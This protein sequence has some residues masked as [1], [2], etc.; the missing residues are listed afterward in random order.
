MRARGSVLLLL[1][2]AASGCAPG[3]IVLLPSPPSEVRKEP[4]ISPPAPPS[5]PPVSPAPDAA[6]PAVPPAP[7]PPDYPRLYEEAIGRTKDAISRG[8]P[9]SAIPSWKALE[10]SPWQQ[11]A[12]F[13]QGVLLQLA[14]D[15]D[16][17]KVH[18]IHLAGETPP[19]EPAAANLLG[20]W[21]LRGE[22]EEARALAA[23]LLPEPGAP[24]SGM[25]PELQANL[26]A[27]LAEEG[28]FVQ[29]AQWIRALRA[30]GFDAPALTWNLAVLAYRNGDVAAARKLAGEIPPE[31]ASLWP[32]AASRF[33]WDP[34]QEKAPVFDDVPAAEPRMAA[35]A[36]NLRA[37][38]VYRKGNAKEAGT[39]LAEPAP[40]KPPAELLS[41]LGILAAEQGRWNEARE[42]LERAVREAPLLAA[43]WRNL[44]IFLDIYAGDP[45]GARE[46]YQKYGTLN[47]VSKE[48]VQR[49]AEWLGRSAPSSP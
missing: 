25:L 49:W 19:H 47:G 11:D 40:G 34:E 33:A 39:I 35:L 9:E 23:R 27:F 4:A 41:N 26:A 2:L 21:L 30:R 31:T 17:A 7:P 24:P 45:K 13:H 16:R 14:G 3:R 29:A 43:G 42:A 46:C 32:V 6:R 48:E 36:R 15:L 1:V 37:Y 8:I 22:R 12:L 20:I 44:G 38:Q 10:E 28:K 18:Y 5:A